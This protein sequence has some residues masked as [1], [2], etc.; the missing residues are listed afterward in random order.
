ME[1]IQT[2]ALYVVPTIAGLVFAWLK[3]RA[4]QY[5]K[6][7]EALEAGVYSAWEAYGRDRKKELSGDKF[8]QED[9]EKLRGMAKE[10]AKEVLVSQGL[11]LDKIIPE[12]SLQDLAIK[13]IVTKIK[14]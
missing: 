3:R 4:G 7:L 9:R 6:A 1:I 5:S 8:T 2:I 13:K 14:S 10:T 11:K 12:G